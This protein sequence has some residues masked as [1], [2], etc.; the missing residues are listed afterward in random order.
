MD[1]S[2]NIH[3][4]VEG[5][6]NA[7][8]AD[9]LFN[10]LKDILFSPD[11]ARIEYER[12][13][14]A[15]KQLGEG[16]DYLLQCVNENRC[17]VTQL[18]QGNLDALPPSIENPISAP[19]KELQGSLRHLAWQ[20]KQIARGDY[21]QR[22]DFMGGFSEGFNSMVSQL[23]E[24]TSKLEDARSDAERRNKELSQI[25][26]LF[27]VVMNN[28]PDYLVVLDLETNGEYLMNDIAKTLKET[29]PAL[30]HAVRKE[31]FAHSQTYRT[32][33]SRWDL[34][35]SVPDLNN[36]SCMVEFHFNILTYP[37]LWGM[38][39][40]M[41]H[42]ISDHTDEV[43]KERALM[44]D[45]NTDPLTNLFNRRY[46]TEKLDS[47]LQQDIQ[48]CITLIDIDHLKYC[49]DSFGHEKGD[50][51]LHNVGIFLS[52]YLEDSVLCRMGG[53][54]F[55]L[56]T[57]NISV[58]YQ[59]EQLEALRS[60]FMKEGIEGSSLV[61]PLPFPQSFSFGTS[62]HLPHSGI[63]SSA[64]LKEADVRMYR[65][66]SQ[67]KPALGSTIDYQETRLS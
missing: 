13:P 60:R 23:A 34:S 35:V 50:T 36:P 43:E 22:V 51:Y 45:A 29:N 1:E 44:F 52:T 38:R 21:S 12:L 53:D 9:I 6:S 5:L 55:L 10:C 54:E 42:I 58:P 8:V 59:D 27:L 62:E 20:T 49:N 4:A 18:S 30:P 26:D 65:Y 40:A 39:Q 2:N 15:F 17:F 67:F 19:A 32:V 11:S 37:M 31:L 63:T 16:L 64:L 41:V 46:A 14:K 56:M 66:K 47:W 61:E 7:Q 33:N 57:K 24:R 48:F 3:Q 28:S 25:Q